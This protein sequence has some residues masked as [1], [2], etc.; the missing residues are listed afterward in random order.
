MLLRWPMPVG[1]VAEDCFVSADWTEADMVAEEAVPLPTVPGVADEEEGG[2]CAVMDTGELRSR[3]FDLALALVRML[4]NPGARE[5]VV[6]RRG[7]GVSG[8]VSSEFPTIIKES[9]LVN[10]SLYEDW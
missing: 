3:V 9:K 8:I 7:S 10:E 6:F 5:N 1:V 2:D 4:L